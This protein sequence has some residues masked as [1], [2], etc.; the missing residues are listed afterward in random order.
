M[1]AFNQFIESMDL[2]DISMITKRFTWYSAQ[3]NVKSILGRVLISQELLDLWL[4]SK[5]Y[6]LD[7]SLYNHYAFILRH[8]LIDLGQA[9]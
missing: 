6:V 2:M 4:E 3:K 1:L 7:I 9:I 8:E 5:Q